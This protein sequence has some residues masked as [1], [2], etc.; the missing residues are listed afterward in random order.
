MKE[1]IFVVI[2]NWNGIRETLSCLRS[3]ERVSFSDFDFKVVVVDNGSNDDSVKKLNQ[4][5]FKFNL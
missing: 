5:R 4:A 1:K 2:L 3:L